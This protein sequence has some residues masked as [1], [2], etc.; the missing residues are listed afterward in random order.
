[1]AGLICV[2]GSGD[3]RARTERAAQPLLRRPWHRVDVAIPAPDVAL[4]F[5][6]ERGAVAEHEGTGVTVAFDGELF[7]D[8]GV[9]GGVE[10]A[11]ILLQAY[12]A[13]GQFFD[14]PQGLFA[15]A[16]WD[17]RTQ[18]L[19]VVNDRHG[20]R[21]VWTARV[22][23]ALIVASE[24]KALLAAGLEPK[25]ELQA[26]AEFLAYESALGQHPLLQGTRL[27]PPATTL[28]IQRDGEE[29]LQSRWRY[30]LEPEAEADEDEL[31][32]EF[33]RLLDLAVV[34][35]VTDDTALALSGGLDS[36]S[37]ASVLRVRAP[38]SVAITWGTPGSDDLEL[39]TRLAATAGLVHQ[40]SPFEP[41]FI[42]RG[43]EE[44]VWLTEGHIRCFHV[45]HRD[46]RMLRASH[47]SRALIIGF[48]GDHVVRTTGGPLETGDERVS[49][50][51]FHRWRAACVTDE[52]LEEV[53]TPAFASEMRGRARQSMVSMLE[54]EEG[55][56]LARIRQLIYKCQA[57]K[58]WP[59]TE[60]FADDLGPRDPFDDIDLVDFCRR[61]PEHFR[62]GGVLHKA[63]LRQFP[64]LAAVANA[65]EG[66]P[67]AFV[68]SRRRLAKLRVRAR[69]GLDSK[70]QSRLGP[71][72]WPT[73]HG[74]GDYAVDLHRHGAGLLR[75]LLEPRTLDRGQLRE[76]GVRRLVEETI[77]GRA[78][79]TR[80]LGVLLT[81]EFFQRQFVDGDG[82]EGAGTEHS[83][84][85]A[86]AA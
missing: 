6:G 19:T 73:N 21:P 63:F 41:G 54:A 81:F 75:T 79:N 50:P 45:H 18:A 69:K 80:A 55:E 85:K 86:A 64:D 83:S 62:R 20:R 7:F 56:P 31:V 22:D 84:A 15:A 28:V 76:Q 13:E 3:A 11:N 36:R 8:D 57:R 40:R 1:V 52:L 82:Y 72:R 49:P 67:I 35:R 65:K 9:R 33:G 12:V 51:A 53:F 5:A 61:M 25:L 42:A 77:S 58:I 37:V 38:G 66:V 47:G 23:D 74:I 29:R 2:V 60:L 59:Q 44:A 78:R 70:L 27:L 16:F 24:Q 46:A 32:A 71:G 48:G 34:R 26:W 4:A 43:A 14:P 39:G 10:A 68:G 30:R 17:P